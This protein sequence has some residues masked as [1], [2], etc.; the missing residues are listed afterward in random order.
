MGNA[1]SREPQGRPLQKQKLSKHRNATQAAAGL[2]KPNG[3]STT[4]AQ[5]SPDTS[6]SDL[7][8]IPYSATATPHVLADDDDER[9]GEVDQN[10]KRHSFLGSSKPQRRLSLF[11]SK[12][13]QEASDRRKSRRNTIVGAPADYPA[14]ESPPVVRAN[15]VNTH[16]LASSNRYSGLLVPENRSPAGCRASWAHDRS[17]E[18]QQVFNRVQEQRPGL[19][20]TNT[21]NSQFESTPEEMQTPAWRR[22][23]LPVQ[24]REA[25]PPGS[26]TISRTNSEVSMHPPM[27]RRSMVQTPGVATRSV[28][29]GPPNARPSVRRSHTNTSTLVTHASFEP[30]DSIP[31]IPPL[32]TPYRLEENVPR[33]ATPKDG[34]YST[35]GAFKLGT[36]RITNGSPDATPAGSSEAEPYVSGPDYFTAMPPRAKSGKE[37]DN[38]QVSM[39]SAGLQGSDVTHRETAKSGSGFN[40]KTIVPSLSITV[41]P[42]GP[43]SQYTPD[44]QISPI[45]IDDTPLFRPS[46]DIQTKHTAVEDLLFEMEDDSQPEIPAV[47]KLDVRLDPSAKSLP[48]QPLDPTQSEGVKRTDSGFVSNSVSVSSTSNSSLTKADSGYSSNASLRSFRSGKKTLAAEKDTAR[49]SMESVRRTPDVPDIEPRHALELRFSSPISAG[50]SST[51]W[52]PETE[53]APT[54]PPK[55]LGAMKQAGH[56]LPR[57]ADGDDARAKLMSPG[58]ARMKAVRHQ[59]PNID[60]SKSEDRNVKFFESASP[61]PASAKSDTEV[62]SPLSI[63]SHSQKHGRL[64]RL[65]SLRSSGFSRAPLTAHVTHAVDEQVPSVPRDVEEKLRE[66]TGRFPMTTKRLALRSQMSKETLKTILSVGSLELAMEDE[67]PSTPVFFDTDSDNE[68]PDR[69]SGDAS[70]R[71]TINSMQSNFKQA[72]ASMMPNRK[73]IVRKPVPIRKESQES[74]TKQ[75]VGANGLQPTSYNSVNNSLGGNTYDVAV[76]ALTE[77]QAQHRNYPSRS[78]TLTEQSHRLQLRTYSL[79]S[80]PSSPRGMHLSPPSPHPRAVSP[81]KKDKSQP[82]VSMDTRSFRTPPPRSPLNPQGPAVLRKKSQDAMRNQTSNSSDVPPVPSLD[83][84]GSLDSIRQVV[85]VSASNYLAA[86]WDF[87][88]HQ[89]APGSHSSP[90][91]NRNYSSN[92]SAPSDRAHRLA[93]AHQSGQ[94][95]KGPVPKQQSNLDIVRNQLQAVYEPHAAH[96]GPRPRSL[97]HSDNWNSPKLIEEHQWNQ[98]ARYPPYV[99]R[100]QHRRNQSAG[101]QPSHGMGHPPY[102]ILHSYNSPAYRNAPIWG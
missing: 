74:E 21:L 15:S 94:Q 84:R 71:Q 11:R 23:S 55:D 57:N 27:R 64:H 35:T 68:K 5:P 81:P 87:Q 52:D 69:A 56:S 14:P 13:S 100:G 83:R 20:R 34:E 54:P 49:G 47:E 40:S 63:G 77:D 32:P 50:D 19:P 70:L 75:A 73:S 86:D 93:R 39:L 1:P 91:N 62:V 80:M 102:R 53:K 8:T 10:D 76:K 90:L 22:R 44:L 95:P 66:H 98:Y 79:N 3:P 101:S 48:P 46:L 18:V 12:S 92:P 82:P 7:I 36:L 45:E 72:A 99:P 43:I 4:S 9:G 61:I 65:L 51:P 33:V 30:D 38:V 97:S 85:A 41:P 78:M 24:A 28:R 89:T 60:V 42:S 25:R 58:R 31:S 29:P 67:L 37:V 6:T 26:V 2:L 16:N 59:L 96:Q 17:Y 88:A